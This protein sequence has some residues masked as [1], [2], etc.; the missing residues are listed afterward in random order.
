[1]SYQPAGASERKIPLNMNVFEA[2]TERISWVFD[3][4]SRVCVSF[5]GGKDSTLLFHLTAKEAR[6]RGRT[7][8]VLFIDWEVQFE[9]TINHVTTMK[10]LYQDCTDAF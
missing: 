3:S 6:R 9:Y 8:S 4:F 1:M 10:A 5:S 2:T 7:F